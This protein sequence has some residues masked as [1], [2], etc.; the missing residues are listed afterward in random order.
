MMP[1]MTIAREKVRTDN[2]FDSAT[3][4]FFAR[5]AARASKTAKNGGQ[6]G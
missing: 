3:S 5:Q 1:I 4:L 6:F 2:R